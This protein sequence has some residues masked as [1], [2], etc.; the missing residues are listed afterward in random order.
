MTASESPA[1]FMA[2]TD[3]LLSI[4]CAAT[5]AASRTRQSAM[6]RAK[7]RR[8]VMTWSPLDVKR[9]PASKSAPATVRVI[10]EPSAPCQTEA[11]RGTVADHLEGLAAADAERGGGPSSRA[12]TATASPSE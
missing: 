8:V 1:F 7:V 5:E 2:I 11:S 9:D 10:E 4:S 12:Q 3:S 6:R